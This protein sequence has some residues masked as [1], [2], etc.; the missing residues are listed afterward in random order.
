MDTQ[1]DSPDMNPR[2]RLFLQC[3]LE[4]GNATKAYM[5]AYKMSEE[6]R[7]SASVLACRQLKKVKDAFVL[8]LEHNGLDDKAI[9]D[10]LKGALG[11]N[12]QQVY[13]SKVYEFPDFYARM[14]A[15]ELL[16]KLTGRGSK[17]ELTKNQLNIQVISDPAKGIFKI[18]ED[19]PD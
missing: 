1:K 9:I 5:Q 18:T 6:H 10:V 19:V 3:Y 12:R 8:L 7:A 14:K 11:A 17:E 2:Q 16:A 13:H 4:S 15:I